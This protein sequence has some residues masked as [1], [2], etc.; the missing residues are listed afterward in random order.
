MILLSQILWFLLIIACI[1]GFLIWLVSDDENY[2]KIAGFCFCC[3]ISYIFGYYF[4]MSHALN[5]NAAHYEQTV[6]KTGY[7]TNKFIWGPK[8]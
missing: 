7:V 4:A 3:L 5:L 1:S 8:K 2:L 6:D